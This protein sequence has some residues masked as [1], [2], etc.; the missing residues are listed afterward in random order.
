MVNDRI[1]LK[2]LT[3]DELAGVVNL[4]PWFGGA[5]KE[6]CQRMSRLDGGEW[7]ERDYAVS[8]LYMGSRAVI[9]DILR[10]GRT[11]DY[12]DR[13][14]EELLKAYTAGKGPAEKS[15]AKPRTRVVGGDFFSQDEYDSVRRGDDNIFSSF[16]SKAKGEEVREKSEQE[17]LEGFCTET[18][19]QIY[20]DQGYYEQAKFIYSK[21]LLR[22]PE[23]SAYFAALIEKLG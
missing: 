12:S 4:Y 15:D 22:Y 8:A 14:L 11:R 3:L 2:S 19:A 13:D 9:A 20:V 10:S 18:L 21:L 6:L 17:V 7:G 1:N 16:A 5:R 23:K